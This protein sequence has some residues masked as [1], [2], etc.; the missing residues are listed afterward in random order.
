MTEETKHRRARPVFY[1]VILLSGTLLTDGA[2]MAADLGGLESVT[3]WNTDSETIQA[4]A[5]QTEADWAI[6]GGG[7]GALCN[8]GSEFTGEN[9]GLAP[10]LG[11][12]PLTDA[13][14]HDNGAPRASKVELGRL[15]M[16]DKI[17]SG[18]H[19]ISCATCHHPF[20]GTGDGLSLPIGEGGRGLGVT[21]DTGSGPDA[22]HERVPRNAPHVWNEGAKQ[23]TVMFHDGRVSVDPSEPS[24]FKTPAG[25]DLP[26]NLENIL[27][28]QA[29]F[30][31]TSGT[32]MAGQLGENP[33]AD[34]A[35]VGNLA[36]PGGVWEQLADRLRAI[37]EYVALFVEA[38][39]D[40]ADASDITFAHAANAISAFERVF[41][42]ADNSPF[43]RFLR[44]ERTA[45]SGNA[46]RGMVLFYDSQGEG[47]SCGDCHSGVL[48]TDHGFHAIGM[49]Q[50][51]A[52]KGDGFDGH[53]DF[54]LGRETG[55]I[56]DRYR[57]RTPSLR[58][59]ALNAPYGHSGAYNTLRAVVEHH[60]DTVNAVTHYDQSQAKL[61]SRPDLDALDFIV[62]N[63]PARVAEIAAHSELKEPL[64][65]S[66]REIDLLVEFL[67]ALTDPD[68][69]DKRDDVPTRVPSGLPVAD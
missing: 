22:V 42:R 30:P 47:K 9:Y 39:N 19:T 60:I 25:N 10:G 4:A 12:S 34:A 26:L 5:D 59:V 56:A 24:G 67:N 49:P 51:G 41:W 63:D 8:D 2:A 1:R 35:A 65:Y 17:L 31:V 16:F 44:G 32:E 6:L 69:V 68:S 33:I 36:G 57:F 52:G 46:I 45:M 54:G 50:V 66:A 7:P 21:R 61:P 48:Q 37:P 3:G 62:M 43:D 27:A 13:D 29:M 58:N 40:I 23:F 55:A 15:L 18:N 53:D 28:A 14:F 64:A 20:A 11:L 38:F